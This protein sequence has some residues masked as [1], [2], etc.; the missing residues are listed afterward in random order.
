MNRQKDEERV[1]RIS[2]WAYTFGCAC[3]WG[4]FMMPGNI[5]LP[6]AGPLGS[7]IGIILAALIIYFIGS[8]ISYMA[9]R[10][11]EESGMHVYIGKILGKDHGFLSAWA[12]L[13][14]YLSIMW[15]NVTAVVLLIRF[16]FAD[17]LQWGIHYTIAG[18]DVYLGEILVTEVIL[19]AMALLT[20]YGKLAVRL[21]HVVF[22]LLQILFVVVL[23]V[24]VLFVGTKT[25]P[26]T[27]GFAKSSVPNGMEVLNI[28]MLG[29]WMFVGFE[30]VTYMINSGGRKEED[31]RR[32]L[33]FAVVT[34]ALAY[35]LPVLLPVF[36][37]PKGYSDWSSYL[38]ASSKA[39]DLF[40][41]P[42]FYSVTITMGKAGLVML[43]V[44]ILCAI[45]TSLFGLYRAT[46]RLLQTMSHEELMPTVVGKENQYKEPAVAVF[47]I[48]G[49]S[50]LI[51]FFGRTAIGWIVDVTTIS[52]TIVYVYSMWGSL[53]LVRLDH[54]AHISV[55]IKS[56]VGMLA[57]GMSFFFL[58][59]P[60]VISQNELATESYCIL[61]IW[62]IL[63]L[64]YYWYI[65]RH[66]T[67]R[68]Y[69][70]STAMWIL[71]VFLIFFSTV[72]WIRQRTMEKTVSF[73][74]WER[75]YLR[76]FLSTNTLILM[77]VVVLVLF[78]LFSLFSIMLDRQKEN[79]AKMMESEMRSQ[80]KS[81]FLFNVSH[82]IRTPMNAILGFTDL[83]LLDEEISDKTK[84]SLKKIKASGT[85]LLAL[86]N[87]VLEMSRIE[88][89]KMDF[90][91]A[92]TDLQ[93]LFHN[94]D[95]IMRGQADAKSQTLRVDASG[96]THPYVLTDALRLNQVL[97]NLAS[98]AIKYTQEGGQV[99]ISI[100]EEAVFCEDGKITYRISVKDNGFGMSPEFAE[101]IFESFEREKNDKTRG[102]Q[103]TGLGMAITKQIV[104]AMGGE[105]SVKTKEDEGSEFTIVVSFEIA[106]EEEIQKLRS[107]DALTE[108][109]F[110]GMRVLLTDDVDINR[111]IGMAILEMYGFT[112]EEACDGEDA[113]EKIVH[114]PDNYYD[115]ILLDIQ[116]PKLN[117]YETA[118]AIRNL[119]DEKKASLP[120]LAMTANAFEEDKQNAFA[121]G[122]NGHVAKPIDQEQLLTE[123]KKVLQNN[124]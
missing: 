114:A 6:E 14:A 54:D 19:I 107:Q 123:L 73:G 102:I 77:A 3:G 29:P 10:F 5:F 37:L 52:A 1:G 106:T 95:S 118:K 7:L 88:N 41:L 71:M 110:T 31:V 85:H 66:D 13:L 109:D 26:G 79:D 124:T 86:I 87:D 98:N 116:M 64:L 38:E 11:P 51:P 117:G 115:I 68:L 4:A 105:I 111:E 57:A 21:L 103:G 56:I 39:S 100:L 74:G 9:H 70:Q 8:S 43:V 99:E 76:H 59:V 46:A 33:P 61:A 82:D 28:C 90:S 23:F 72:M 91:V 25:A 84:D 18:Y 121:A 20:V 75:E 36:A 120:I 22:A 15:A 108:V 112:V 104:D 69:G 97:I 92:P 81:S 93:E 2:A 60:N 48:M 17:V 24:G 119:S 55:K 67:G 80:A 58:L 94:L 83:A 78:F 89:G 32:T 27:F 45:F 42:V 30:A 16:L 40:G 113:L 34:S 101:H 44:S 63:G 50:L 53:R 65:Y 35:L 122:M 47:L 12:M 96:L 62:S 49:I